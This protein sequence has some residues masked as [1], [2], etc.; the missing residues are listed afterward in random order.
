[1]AF[2][3][4]ALLSTEQ[5]LVP[6]TYTLTYTPWGV[7]SKEAR[8]L[9][10]TE[11][12]ELYVAVKKGKKVLASGKTPLEIVMS[13]GIYTLEA[14]GYFPLTIGLRKG[15]K[16]EVVIGSKLAPAP[17]D[18]GSSGESHIAPDIPEGEG[19]LSL[20]CNIAL[21]DVYI[22]D[23]FVADGFT[24]AI[25]GKPKDFEL[26]AGEHRIMV[27]KEGYRPWEGWVLIYPDK[28]TVL[29][30]KLKPR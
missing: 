11:G 10:R 2:V 21:A 13:E 9:V 29:E 6:E 14:D 24:S 30:V 17:A 4:L 3:L 12:T 16:L 28:T 15:W 26:E 22:D 23:F 27:T 18:T 7:S 8:L 25:E 1:M 5:D 19:I 20:I